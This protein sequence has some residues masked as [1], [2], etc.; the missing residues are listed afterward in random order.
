MIIRPC[1]GRSR[2]ILEVRAVAAKSGR[3]AGGEVLGAR[4][5]IGGAGKILKGV[6]G[7]SC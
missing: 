5:V 3:L 7:K 1:G 2:A 6:V 4:G